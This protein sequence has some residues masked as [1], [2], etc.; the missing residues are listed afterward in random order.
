MA[1]RKSPTH[2]IAL[3]ASIS[4]RLREIRQELFGDRGGPELARRLNLPV[5]VWYN[6]ESGVTVPAEVLLEFIEMTGASPVWLLTGEGPKY[7]G[8]AE[9]KQD[10]ELAP[11][12]LLRRGLERL[13]ATLGRERPDAGTPPD[14]V[15]I[16]LFPLGSLVDDIPDDSGGEGEVLATRDWI[17][18]PERTIAVRMTDDSMHPML[19]E[20]SIVAIDLSATDPRVL[21]G[22]IVAARPGGVPLIRWFDRSGGHLIFRPN[23]PGREFPAIP[24]ESNNGGPSPL[25]GAVVFSWN[26]IGPV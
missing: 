10:G 21:Q 15:P 4:E 13:E 14:Y 25:I 3:K 24:I 8:P 20:G 22:Q 5:R 19:A 11:I 7:N 17:A 18:N 1:R 9:G 6:Y 23:Q 16:R 26:R 2:R 12:E